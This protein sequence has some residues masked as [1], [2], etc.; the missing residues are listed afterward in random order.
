[1]KHNMTALLLLACMWAGD[2]VGAFLDGNRLL[3]Y[4]NAPGGYGEGAC[5]GYIAGVVDSRLH[6]QDK[7]ITTAGFCLP[8]SVNLG[9]VVW[10]VSAYLRRHPEELHFT[11]DSTVLIAL[12]QAF[13]C[14]P[15]GTD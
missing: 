7:G 1:M 8:D 13:P 14:A 9:Q 4:C 15:S 3:E 6:R 5:D 2:G 12:Q 10:Q 11:A